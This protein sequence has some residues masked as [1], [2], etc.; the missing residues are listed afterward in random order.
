MSAAFKG[1]WLVPIALPTWAKWVGQN[2]SGEWF[3]FS[4]EPTPIKSANDGHYW[5]LGKGISNLA[6]RGEPNPEGWIKTLRQI[7]SDGRVSDPVKI[8]VERY[9]KKSSPTP[10][11]PRLTKHHE[12]CTCKA[13]L[14]QKQQKK[15]LPPILETVIKD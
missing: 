5:F 1:H 10:A 14:E 9:A 11:P 4:D 2:S 8:T 7:S 15:N 3:L 6:A 13:R 12:K